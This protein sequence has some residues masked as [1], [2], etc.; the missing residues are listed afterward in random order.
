MR[1][2]LDGGDRLAA[3]LCLAAAAGLLLLYGGSPVT[4]DAWGYGYRTARWISEHGMSPV[5]AGGRGEQAMGHPALFFWLWALL[6]E[7]LGNTALVAHLLPCALSGLCLWATWKLGRALGGRAAGM[8][9]SL[10]LLASPLFLA[11]SAVPLTDVGFAAFAALALW[12]YSEDRL[13]AAAVWTAAATVCR[14]PAVVLAVVLALVELS[15]DRRRLRRLLPL[16]LSPLVLVVTGISNLAVNGW[17]FWPQHLGRGAPLPD[18]WLRLKLAFFGGHLFLMDG[19]WLVLVVAIAAAL[20]KQSRKLPSVMAV[21]LLLAPSLLFPPDRSAFMAVAA[22]FAAIALLR[23]GRLPSQAPLAAGLFMLAVVAFH[24]LITLM[25]TFGMIHMYRYMLGAYP[26]FYACALALVRVRGGVRLLHPTGMLLLALGLAAGTRI[27]P[28]EPDSTPAGAAV[29]LD[30]EE[31][32][33]FSDS[34]ADTLVVSEIEL[35]LVTDPALGLVDRPVPARLPG[36]RPP[37][38]GT[39]YALV[40][41]GSSTDAADSMPWPGSGLHAVEALGLR[42][43]PLETT[44]FLIR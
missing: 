42:R 44:V 8:W 16:L 43:G 2:A 38:P 9:S 31:A 6:M 39:V 30:L 10:C 24:A 3:L 33:A 41:T 17:F 14:E 27:D 20:A 22:A 7:V 21:L 37:V 25:T 32:V 19:R 13:A 4:G 29:M 36:G 23:E 15:R 5:P 28:R 40:R 18:G 26:A 12:S 35:A 34:L 1:R 11:Q